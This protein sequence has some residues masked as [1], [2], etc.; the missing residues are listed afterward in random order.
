MDTYH[1]GNKHKL[2]PARIPSLKDTVTPEG[3][4]TLFTDKRF[5]LVGSFCLFYVDG[6]ICYIVYYIQRVCYQS[7]LSFL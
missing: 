1:I 4:A 3:Y 2:C 6:V 7:V 5:P